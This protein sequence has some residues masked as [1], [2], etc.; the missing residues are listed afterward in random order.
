MAK[1]SNV[2]LKLPADFLGNV[3]AFLNA[4]PPKKKAKRKAPKVQPKVTK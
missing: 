1:K 3:Q 2:K 4:P